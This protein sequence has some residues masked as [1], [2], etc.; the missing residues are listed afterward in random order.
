MF[1]WAM[2]A[3]EALERDI[4]TSG[5]PEPVAFKGASGIET[6]DVKRPEAQEM[7]LQ[8]DKCMQICK[9]IR[10]CL[11]QQVAEVNDKIDQTKRL[12]ASID[13]VLSKK[14]KARIELERTFMNTGKRISEVAVER[15]IRS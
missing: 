10:I 7:V 8:L 6:P 11:Q 14:G 3:S 1:K 13:N 5:D 12:Q 15:A 4:M 9:Y 2:T